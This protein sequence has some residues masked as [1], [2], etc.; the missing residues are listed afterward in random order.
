MGDS[1]KVKNSNTCSKHCVMASNKYN[2]R[3]H[4]D[5]GALVQFLSLVHFGSFFENSRS[6][7]LKARCGL[8]LMLK[9]VQVKRGT[10]RGGRGYL[11]RSPP[12]TSNVHACISE[13]NDSIFEV[14]RSIF[15]PHACIFEMLAC[16]FYPRVHL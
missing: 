9:S 12:P 16:I 15:Y 5:S 8:K 10:Y 14:H 7:G 1:M 11:R 4:S 2:N 13:V 6:S 3:L